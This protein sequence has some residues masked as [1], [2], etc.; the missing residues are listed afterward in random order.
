MSGLKPCQ[1]GGEL[2]TSVTPLALLLAR[3]AQPIN[4]RKE[5][6][7]LVKGQSWK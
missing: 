4:S 3:Q 5:L 2:K 6:L 1:L 7:N